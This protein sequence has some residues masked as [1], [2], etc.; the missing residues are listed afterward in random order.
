[1]VYQ[2]KEWNAINSPSKQTKLEWCS[3]ST[4][5]PY[6][7]STCTLD[8]LCG[9]WPSWLMWRV[10]V[11]SWR[12]QFDFESEY[13]APFL[14]SFVSFVRL[15]LWSAR[16]EGELWIWYTVTLPI[17]ILRCCNWWYIESMKW[18]SLDPM[19]KSVD[20]AAGSIHR[21]LGENWTKLSQK[22]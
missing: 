7:R 14:L 20:S 5:D 12:L 22:Q 13:T 15:S 16:R 19:L 9:L 10:F 2:T 4:P 1:M 21:Y 18:G 11:E 17:S 3:A 6:A 8:D